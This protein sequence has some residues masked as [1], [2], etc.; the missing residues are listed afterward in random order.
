MDDNQILI[1]D[2]FLALYSDR[3]QRLKAPVATIRSRYELCE[4]LACQLMPQ[5]N[6]LY[7]DGPSEEGVLLGMHMGL[8]SEGSPVS[9]DE[10]DWVVLR[11]AELLDWRSPG[12]PPREA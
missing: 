8:A 11:L 9:R 10:A 4:D 12:L 1:P 6:L 2:S 7:D 5:A 3:H